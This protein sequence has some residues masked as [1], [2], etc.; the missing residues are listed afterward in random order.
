[1]AR[2]RELG[3]ALN[4]NEPVFTLVDPASIWALV[5]IDEAR[6]GP[7]EIGQL[8]QVTRRSV[9]DKPTAAKVVRIDIESDR[10]N[11]ERRVYVRCD[12]PKHTLQVGEQ[13]EVRIT[14][15]TLPSARL[16]KLKSLQD[17][18]RREATAWTVENGRLQQR[19]VT[20]GHRTL[21]GRVEISGGV[22]DGSEIVD[23]AAAGL[24]IGRQAVITS[25]ARQ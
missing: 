3:S 10:V 20:L 15:A 2:T 4:A 17:V 5:Y 25:E 1:M 21:D 8:A 9:P 12:N 23:D 22:P 6:A 18:Q 14:V 19:R 16:V 24:K 7:I 13:A 11:E